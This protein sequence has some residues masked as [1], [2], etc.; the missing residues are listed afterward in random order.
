V[1]PP[2]SPTVVLA[3]TLLSL[4]VEDVT[5]VRASE[6]RIVALLEMGIR[7]SAT[8]RRLVDAL[9]AS[10]VLVYIEPKRSR[11]ALGGYLAHDV[12]VGDMFRYLRVRITTLAPRIGCWRCSPT[13]CSTRSKPRRLQGA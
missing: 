8:F 4:M 12:T 5:H 10:D 6:P 11:E 1:Q 13:S 7:R 9:N 2:R 3:A